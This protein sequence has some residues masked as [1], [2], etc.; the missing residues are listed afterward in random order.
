MSI[1]KSTGNRWATAVEGAADILLDTGKTVEDEIEVIPAVQQLLVSDNPSLVPSG[2]E[3]SVQLVQP[4]SSKANHSR[5]STTKSVTP[6]KSSD[7]STSEVNDMLIPSVSGEAS[8]SSLQHVETEHGKL[9]PVAA[10]PI[11]QALT[12]KGRKSSGSRQRTYYMDNEIADKIASLATE[13]DKSES[14][15]LRDLL[16]AVF[17]MAE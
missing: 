8:E 6:K 17:K 16:R 10:D 5:K 11:Q 7:S 9:S 4:D 2:E 12:I 1:K 13:L 3:K 15:L 14:Q